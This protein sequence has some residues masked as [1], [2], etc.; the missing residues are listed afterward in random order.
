MN[1][2]DVLIACEESAAVRE[3]FRERGFNAW[4]CDLQPTSVPGQHIQGDVLEVLYDPRWKLIIAHPPCDY[5]ANSGARW[6]YHPDDLKQPPPF[7]RPHPLYPN[8]AEDRRQAI[9]FF[10]RFQSDRIK[11]PVA[12]ENPIPNRHST[13][14][15]GKYSQLIQ[16]WMFGHT[17]QKATC[18]W[19]RDLPLLVA[20]DN[21]KREM[22]ELPYAERGKL[23][24]LPPSPD[25]K[26]LRSKTYP[27]IA[28]AMALQWGNYIRGICHNDHH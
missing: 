10:K 2:I 9:E 25:R 19:L 7:R 4:S 16:P 22:D 13:D 23:H 8:R 5:L 18:L 26:K 14:E 12:I 1:E 27:G 17:E 20:T 3:A 15:I 21:V 11:C 24:S 6:F 28:T